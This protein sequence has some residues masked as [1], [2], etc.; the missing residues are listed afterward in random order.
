M[1]SKVI[2]IISPPFF[3]QHFFL[4][5]HLY[6]QYKHAVTKAAIGDNS[7]SSPWLKKSLQGEVRI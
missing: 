6:T 1:S 2:F 3:N 4:S 7:Q 5:S